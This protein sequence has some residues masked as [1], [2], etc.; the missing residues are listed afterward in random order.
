[1]NGRLNHRATSSS[2]SAKTTSSA[3]VGNNGAANNGAASSNKLIE[4]KKTRS[5]TESGERLKEEDRP[6]IKPVGLAWE[7][8]PYKGSRKPSTVMGALVREMHPDFVDTANGKRPVLTWE[9]YKRT[10]TCGQRNDRRV[11][12][13]FWWRFKC[14]PTDRAESDRVLERNFTKRVTQMISEEKKNAVHGLYKDDKVPPDETDADGNRWPTVEAL[15]SAK[16]KDF[17]TDEGWRLLCE[18][19][20]TP[21]FRKKSLLG[22]R[23]R[24]AGGDDAV[25]H[26]NGS[27]SLVATR[28][29]L[30]FELSRPYLKRSIL[31]FLEG[32]VLWENFEF[33]GIALQRVPR[34]TP[35][36]KRKMDFAPTAENGY[37]KTALKT[38]TDPRLGATWLH[39][40]KLRKGTNDDVLCS[41]NANEKWQQYVRGM[42][43]KY[44]PNWREV[45]PEIDAAVVYE[46]VGRTPKG[47]LAISDEAISLTEKEKI[48]TRKRNVQPRV[49]R[50][51]LKRK[52]TYCEGRTM[53]TGA[54][55]GSCGNGFQRGWDYDAILEE[56]TPELATSESD[57]GF[58][59]D[60]CNTNQDEPEQDNNDDASYGYQSNDDIVVKTM[61]TK[62]TIIMTMMVETM[63]MITTR[64][65]KMMMVHTMEMIGVMI[66]IS[67][68]FLFVNRMS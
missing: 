24:L 37:S 4:D 46:C 30:G 27:R 31:E 25:Y 38:D 7:V 41:D 3:L 47:R 59:K 48:K 20:S 52:L 11:I 29:H 6:L 56:T 2:R 35:L 5:R 66:M 50:Y 44:G 23:N 36:P 57:V 32:H 67:N 62:M 16:P 55:R 58:S 60:K 26:N 45:H 51:D 54:L 1:M 13:E 39:T 53:V 28:Q 8:H 17:T 68:G 49:S 42:E 40:H 19:W 65:L 15:I 43:K 33:L 63:A 22:K 18:H 34:P 10:S 12:G 21:S 14:L 9:D 64:I 61:A